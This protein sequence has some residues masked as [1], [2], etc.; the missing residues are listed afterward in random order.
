[1][2]Y[3]RDSYEYAIW[4]TAGQ[5]VELARSIKRVPEEERHSPDLIEQVMKR[6]AVEQ[7]NEL[8]TVL[9]ADNWARDCA[10][11]LMAEDSL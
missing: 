2:G 8:Q 7:I 4:D 1:M 5:V 6:H 3:V 10:R 9:A 11:Q